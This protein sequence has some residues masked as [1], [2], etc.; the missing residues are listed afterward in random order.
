MPSL[1]RRDFLKLTSAALAAAALPAQTVLAQTGSLG[2]VLVRSASLFAASDY[3]SQRLGSVRF[4][5]LV[6]I[7][8][9]A[10]GPG[11]YRHNRIWLQLEGGYIYSSFVQPVQWIKNAPTLDIGGGRWGEVSVPFTYG[12]G[13]PAAVGYGRKLYYSAVFRVIG[14]QADASGAIWYMLGNN[15]NTFYRWVMGEDLRLIP[16]EEV[17]PIA[18]DVADKKIV[19]DLRAQSVTAFENGNPVFSSHTSTGTVFSDGA[20][21]TPRGKFRV[22]FKRYSRHMTGGQSEERYDLP[23]VSYPVYITWSR[24]A[25]HGTYWHNNFGTPMSHGCINLPPAAAQWVFRWTRPI[26]GYDAI[27]TPETPGDPGTPVEVIG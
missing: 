1:S 21:Y 8:G 7:L 19:V 3:A 12:Y 18:P 11:L 15:S 24:V 13:S 20:Y 27:E 23:G 10:E 17:S 5:D 4:D 16:P 2:R 9:Q 6:T 26:A 22:L 25:L 14:A